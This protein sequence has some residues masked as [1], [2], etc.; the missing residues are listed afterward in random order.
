MEK[1][2]FQNKLNVVIIYV[3]LGLARAGRTVGILVV[4]EDC[5]KGNFNGWHIAF[6]RRYFVYFE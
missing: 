6:W 5:G 4:R 3:G 1:F 2:P